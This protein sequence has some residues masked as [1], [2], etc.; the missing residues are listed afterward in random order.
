MKNT[1]VG[2]KQFAEIPDL[3]EDSRSCA[4]KAVNAELIRL[5]WKTGEY[6]S[7]LCAD[8]SHGD[9]IIDD[10]CD[11]IAEKNPGI[12]GFNRCGLYRM[13]KFYETYRNDESVSSLLTEIRGTNHLVIMSGSRSPEERRFYISL[14]AREHYS[15]REL[16]RQMDSAY[17]E[18]YMLSSKKLVPETVSGNVRKSILD[19]YVLEF[20][21]LLNHTPRRV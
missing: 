3:I 10:V 11:Y 5:Y 17:Y 15:K 8:S 18:R 4:L 14:C 21:D 6:L 9:K 7:S 12:R 2:Q 13:K 20:L 16:E 1:I 19:T